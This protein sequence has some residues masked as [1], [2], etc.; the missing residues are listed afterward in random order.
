MPR[1]IIVENI[2]TID[3][4]IPLVRIFPLVG[5]L[6]HIQKDMC[7]VLIEILLTIAK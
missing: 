3:P 5:A 6:T 1:S 2:P 4:G 7:K